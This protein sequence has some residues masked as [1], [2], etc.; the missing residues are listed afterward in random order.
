MTP[1]TSPPLPTEKPFTLEMVRWDSL[2]R[3]PSQ[4]S[5]PPTIGDGSTTVSEEGLTDGAPDAIGSPSDTTNLSIMSGKLAVSDP[6]GGL[7]TVVLG[8]PSETL[9]S[10][11]IPIVWTGTGSHVLTGSA[12]G[13]PVITVSI[14]DAGAY[15]V[16][17]LGPVDHPDVLSEDTV[18]FV[19]PVKV[20][21]SGGL[22]DSGTLTV[23]IEDDSP[24]V[25]SVTT[26]TVDE[27]GLSGNA[28]DSYASGDATGEVLTATAS[29]NISWGADNADNDPLA[30]TTG[31]RTVT[32][33]ASQAGLSGL[34][35]DGAAVS[36]AILSNGTLVGYTGA[37]A[38]TAS[39]DASVVFFATL[40]DDASGSYNF[41]LKGNLDHP[42]ADT[43]DD[44]N[45]TFAFTA[46]DADGDTKTGTFT[47]IVDDDGLTVGSVTTQTVDEEGLSG[48]A[49]DSY[50]SGDATGEILTA[51]A[52]LNIS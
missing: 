38:P 31:D 48:N 21:D 16:A 28:G 52:S 20:T 39:T 50:A 10:Q 13:T 45:L 1:S 41:T 25:V 37:V 26:Q 5:T 40:N 24:V 14:T 27:E 35:A 7:V 19:A 29:L 32:F 3:P 34:T 18:T 44:L 30:G 4:P 36:I 8:A 51:T 17:I 47:V 43:E 2:A 23:S 49:G 6:D 12:G 22:T 11:G 42:T 9:T 15:T 46:K 33:T